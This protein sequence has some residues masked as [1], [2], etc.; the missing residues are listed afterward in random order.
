MKKPGTGVTNKRRRELASAKAQRQAAR[1]AT[2]RAQHRR[3]LVMGWGRAALVVVVGVAVLALWPRGD[4][5]TTA[6]PVAVEG[7][8]PAPTPSGT[9]PTWEAAPK[10]EL[11]AGTDYQ[12]TLTTN[13]GDIV[14]DT[15]PSEAP[16]T[17]NAMQWLADQGYF[18][19]TL[20][21][22]VTTGNLYVLQCGDPTGTGGGGPGF[23]LP[24]ENLPEDG[25]ANYPAGT[26]AMANRGP[27]TS[28]SQFFIAY[29][30]TTLPADYT[31][32]GTVTSGL[33][34]V[35]KIAEAGVSGGGTDGTP[36]API[37]IVSAQVTTGEG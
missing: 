1:R 23:T 22:R 32:W 14:I 19:N 36:A 31:V 5:Q 6:E 16:K 30:D 25:T 4:A 33:D 15:L 8:G 29:E 26:V 18:D 11:V 20:C 7:C 17:V 9:A 27:G 2:R 13:C 35:T 24:D 3:R 37:G 34:I 21:T 10:D 28:G 12:L